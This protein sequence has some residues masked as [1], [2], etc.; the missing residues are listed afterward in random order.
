[1]PGT[2]WKMS[3]TLTV[4]ALP[5]SLSATRADL[6]HSLRARIPPRHMSA[7]TRHTHAPYSPAKCTSTLCQRPGKR[8]R[9]T[10]STAAQ[11]DRMRP[12]DDATT[13][14]CT[15][16]SSSPP[17]RASWKYSCRIADALI[18]AD[19]IP[20][21]R[22]VRRLY[23]ALY[24]QFD[25]CEATTCGKRAEGAC[26]NVYR[27][28]GTLGVSGPAN[29]FHAF[30]SH[31]FGPGRESIRQVHS[32][33]R[34]FLSPPESS[35]DPESCGTTSPNRTITSR[36]ASRC[37]W[38]TSFHPRRY[39]CNPSQRTLSSMRR[40]TILLTLWFSTA[41]N[42]AKSGT[43]QSAEMSCT[44]TPESLRS[45]DRP[46]SCLSRAPTGSWCTSGRTRSMRSV[47]RGTSHSSC[48]TMKPR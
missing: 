43:T 28:T 17:V 41:G 21:S 44:L 30:S 14:T 48:I 42:A 9:T 29:F 38:L 36:S 37:S 34:S 45:S 13:T 11:R 25:I 2:A 20:P 4:S 33:S 12:T 26:S 1:M 6:S 5:V 7:P 32:H 27:T 40:S 46:D 15:D 8:R 24:S 31:F 22:I 35:S 3:R 47:G 39:A 19:N 18:S 10:R 16:P 23:P